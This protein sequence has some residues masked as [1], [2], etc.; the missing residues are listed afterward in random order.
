MANLAILRK[1]MNGKNGSI[2]ILEKPIK[3]KKPE[4]KAVIERDHLGLYRVLRVTITKQEIELP[5]GSI[6]VDTI[7]TKQI[8]REDLGIPKGNNILSFLKLKESI[9]DYLQMISKCLSAKEL[10][11]KTLSMEYYKIDRIEKEY[12][13]KKITEEE[14]IT[15]LQDC[16]V[17][18]RKRYSP[19]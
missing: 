19:K 13:R 7:E 1:K 18:I 4:E 3:K 15:R 8:Q 11:D 16:N 14:A 17:S 9:E 2:P 10:S 12:T 5:D 6:Q